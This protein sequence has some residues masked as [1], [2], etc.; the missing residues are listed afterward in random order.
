MEGSLYS[1]IY[2]AVFL[3]GFISMVMAIVS[4]AGVIAN[5]RDDR[6]RLANAIAPL[7]FFIPGVLNDAGKR[8]R[9]KLIIYMLLVVSAVA[10][11][12]YFEVKFGKPPYMRQA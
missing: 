9:V 10:C 5:I 7:I 2:V 3:I 8:Y 6:K 11:I 1:I 4:F 12:Y